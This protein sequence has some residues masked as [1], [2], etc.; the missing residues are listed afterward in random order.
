MALAFQNMLKSFGLEDKILAFNADNA[1][2]ND[3]QTT[4]LA[5]FA[6]SFEE[7]N[8]VRCFNHTVQLS[9]KE[10]LKPFN[11]GMSGK[12]WK[13]LNDGGEVEAKVDN[14][15]GEDEDDEDDDEEDKDD[16]SENGD[17]D[18]VDDIDEIDEMSDDERFEIETNT[19]IV[20]ETVTKVYYLKFT[21]LLY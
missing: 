21:M 7:Y 11:A 8:R 10:L 16:D 4:Q 14:G 9:A 15:D 1:T 17:D 5:S 12:L 19:G 20:R 2:S 6:N 13:N 18:P 3:T